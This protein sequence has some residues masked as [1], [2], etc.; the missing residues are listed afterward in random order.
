MKFILAKIQHTY[1]DTLYLDFLEN[2]KNR[3]YCF[4]TA[5]RKLEWRINYYFIVR[6]WNDSAFKQLSPLGY[7]P[8]DVVEQPK[9]F[10]SQSPFV[11]PLYVY[12]L[13]YSTNIS[14]FLRMNRLI[15]MCVKRPH[16]LPKYFGFKSFCLSHLHFVRFFN[17]VVQ[18]SLNTLTPTFTWRGF[19]VE[20]NIIYSNINS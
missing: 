5:L 20:W 17:V 1:N 10:E 15:H 13:N 4:V 11:L 16:D 12:L 19:K 6:I 9:G 14:M 3:W 18:K 7:L 2:V 8:V